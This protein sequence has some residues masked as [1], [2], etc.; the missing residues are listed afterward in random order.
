M[1]YAVFALL[2]APLLMPCPPYSW[3]SLPLPPPSLS[4][5]EKADE[6]V[7]F[8]YGD[9]LT[10]SLH[11]SIYDKTLRQI[12]QLGN[13]EYIEVLLAAHDRIVIQKGQFHQLMHQL[14]GIYSQ[15]YGG[16]MQAMQVANGMKRV[17]GNPVKGGYQAHHLFAVRLYRAANRLMFRAM[18]SG[19]SFN[20]TDNDSPQQIRSIIDRYKTIRESWEVSDHQPPRMVALF[21]K[22]MRS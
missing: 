15:F 5:G 16:F 7:V 3:H 13:R 8:V 19:G 12:T 4:L 10:V 22:S 6:R 9:A 20:E 11:G 18:C 17:N 1:H 21:L 2:V 14:G